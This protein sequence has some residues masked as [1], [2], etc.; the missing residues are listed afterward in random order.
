MNKPEF[1]LII[2][3]GGLHIRMSLTPRSYGGTCISGR[4]P[5]ECTNGTERVS[6]ITELF[7]HLTILCP[8]ISVSAILIH[9]FPYL[10]EVFVG[11]R[12]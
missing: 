1:R 7:N 6:S 4:W 9:Y 3:R 8:D 11:Q 12:E 10:W 5:G 2:S